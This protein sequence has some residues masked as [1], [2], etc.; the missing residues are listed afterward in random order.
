MMMMMAVVGQQCLAVLA[1]RPILMVVM[2]TMMIQ[3]I[4]T[5]CDCADYADYVITLDYRDFLQMLP[6]YITIL[7]AW[8]IC[9]YK[10]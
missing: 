3:A 1:D 4:P 5:S 6:R 2:M 8:K 9:T 7:L 10:L